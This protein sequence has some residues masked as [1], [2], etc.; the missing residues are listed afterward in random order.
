MIGKHHKSAPCPYCDKRSDYF[1][2]IRLCGLRYLHK[3]SSPANGGCGVFYIYEYSGPTDID[4]KVFIRATCYFCDEKHKLEIRPPK[5]NPQHGTIIPCYPCWYQYECD[6]WWDQMD[7][8]IT[9]PDDLPTN[10]PEPK[11]DV[12]IDTDA[13]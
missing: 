7:D 8:S 1:R 11:I 12:S 13:T 9:Y 5:L 4:P 2:I 10:K 3:C 6:T